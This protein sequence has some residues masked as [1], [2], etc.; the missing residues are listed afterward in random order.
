MDSAGA[1]C[2]VLTGREVA[3]LARESPIVLDSWHLYDGAA[4]AL[5]RHRA[6]FAV[7]VAAVFDVS[8]EEAGASYD[9]AVRH[10]PRSGSWFPAFV[11]TDIGL[12][13]AVRPFPVG[14][15]RRSMSLVGTPVVDARKRPDI[16]G[17][18]Y[19]WQLDRRA[20]AVA[21]GGD[22]RLLVTGAGLVSETTFAA[23]GLVEGSELILP[24]A[25]RLPSVTLAVVADQ[26]AAHGLT[27]RAEPVTVERVTGAATVLTFSALH[28]VRIVSRLGDR[29]C[30]GD[31]RLRDG[32]QRA[33]EAT[34]RPLP[35]GGVACASC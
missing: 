13:C 20:E 19:L 14:R 12:R 35:D 8:E 28:G 3:D 9:H 16:K 6:R 21:A 31:G 7:S 32:L 33:L 26:A 25:P 17:I 11:W 34:R 23:L 1:S 24:D 27:A 4:I 5:E 30:P 29:L 22:D 18:D 2:P 10:L 15:L